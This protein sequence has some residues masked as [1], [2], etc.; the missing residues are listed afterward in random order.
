MWPEGGKLAGPSRVVCAKHRA[1]KRMECLRA[2]PVAPSLRG[3]AGP[4]RGA[5]CALALLLTLGTP[6]A[7]AT[8]TSSHP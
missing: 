2:L 6:A 4:A 8:V 1:G 5:L 3:P 7:Y